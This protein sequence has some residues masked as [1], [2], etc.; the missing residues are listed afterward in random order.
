MFSSGGFLENNSLGIGL[1]IT[2]EGLLDGSL[3][4]DLRFGGD[5][6][7]TALLDAMSHNRAPSAFS[8]PDTSGSMP[9]QGRSLALGSVIPPSPFSAGGR[10]LPPLTGF[11]PQAFS[12]GASLDPL[13]GGFQNPEVSPG[14]SPLTHT[15]QNLEVSSLRGDSQH[16]LTHPSLGAVVSNIPTTPAVLG[17]FGNV[18]GNKNVKLTLNDANGTEVTF[19]LKGKGHGQVVGGPAFQ[20]LLITGTDDQSQV[21]IKTKGKQSET[22]ITD[23]IVNGS[24]KELKATTTDLLG[25]LTSTGAI[26]TLELD[27]VA[28]ATQQTVAMG[29]DGASK[30]VSLKFDQ[31]SDVTVQLQTPVK[32][33]EAT[34]WL[35]QNLTLD[36]L[37]TPSVDQLRIDG[38]K[39]RNLAGDFQAGLYLTGSGSAKPTLKQVDIDGQV[40]DGIWQVVG[41]TNKLTFGSTAASWSANIDGNLKQLNVKSEV[42]GTLAAQEIGIIE[43]KGDL[44]QAQILSGTNLGADGLLGG[45]DAASDTFGAGSIRSVKVKG[46]GIDSIV[47]AGLDPVDGVFNN[48]NDQL[49]DELESAIETLVIKGTASADSLFAA[50]V[51]PGKVKIDGLT[52]NPEIDAR[53]LTPSKV[54]QDITAPVIT[55]ALV[56]DTAAGG[57]TNT[58]GITADATIAGTVTDTSGIVSLRAGLDDMLPA[59]FTEITAILQPDGQFSLDLAQ[60]TSI[61]GGAL[62]DG[63]YTLHLQAVDT[64]GNASE[65]IDV[66]FTLDTTEPILELTTP[67]VTGEHSSTARLIGT[68]EDVTAGIAEVLYDLDG[69]GF[70]GLTPDAGG[71]FDQALSAA[72]LPNGSHQLTLE[73]TDVA[74]NTT[75]T[76]LDFQVSE[77]LISGPS[78]STGWALRTIDGVVLAERDSLVSQAT[79]PV[80]LRQ[81]VGSRTLSF[82]L[83]AIFDTSDGGVP[84]RLLVYLVDANDPSQTLLDQGVSGTPVF[85]LKETG[86][87]FQPGLVRYNGTVVEIDVTSLTQVT[88]GILVFQLLNSDGDTGSVVEVSNLA[89]QMDET[90]VVSPIF[91]LQSNPVAPGPAL[92]LSSLNPSTDLNIVLSQVQFD[93]Q[94]GRYTANV[95]VE[96]TGDPVGRQVALVFANLPA[97]VELLNSSGADSN[98]FPYLNLKPSI[99]T[100]GLATGE[101]SDPIQ[102]V[103]DNPNL[104][105]F[106][107]QPQILA[108][109][110]NRAPVFDAVTLPDLLPGGVFR[111]PLQA[112]DPDGDSVTFSLQSDVALPTGELQGD[113]TLVFQPTPDQLG[114]YTFFLVASDGT[115]ETTQEV[116]LNVVS[117]PITTTRISGV[118]QNTDQDPLVGVVIELG[119]AQT[120]TAADG[121]FLLKVNDFADDT[122]KVR[123][124]GISGPDVYPF[125]A[126]KLPLLF[127]H[128][129]FMGVNNVIE[130]PIYLPALDM[131]N[132]QM[133]DPA[134]DVTVTTPNIG[135]AAVMVTAGSLMDQQGNAFEGVLSITEVPTDLTPAALPKGLNPDL[136]VT[137]QPGE[138]VFE[139][140]AA[141]TLPNTAGY[142]PGVEMD[143]W[144][145]NPET[146]DFDK[147]GLGQ[148]SADGSVIETIEGGIRNSSWHFFLPILELF[149][150]VL[151]LAGNRLNQDN[152]CPCPAKKVPSNSEIE[153]HSG[154]LTETHNLVSYQSLGQTRGL[155]LTYDSL[156]ADP[157]PIVH[158][159]YEDLNPEAITNAPNSLKLVAKVTVNGDNFTYQ[160][161]GYQGTDYGLS[162]GEHIWSIPG[163]RGQVDAA[164]QIDLKDLPSG[165]YDYSLESGIYL[166]FNNQ[167]TGRSTTNNSK[168]LHINS[169]GSIF[170]NGWGISGLQELVENP[171]GSVLL[172]DGDG[173][174]MLFQPPSMPEGTYQS[175][176]ADFST[177]EKLADGTF[178]RTMKDQTV[179]GFNG[180]NQLASV[181]DRNG[182]ET[183]YLYDS[184]HRIRSVI[185]PVGLETTF[186]YTNNRVSTITD[187]A[188]RITQL[189]HDAVGNLTRVSDPDGTSRTWEYDTDYH[190]VAEVD[191]RGNREESFFNFAG[192]ATGAVRKDGSVVQVDPL[193]VQ[194]L[195]RPEETI[196]P[197][198]APT[199]FTLS[200]VTA[201]HADGNGNVAVSLLNQVGQVVSATD[202]SGA[203][204]SVE[205]NAQNLI[206][207]QTDARGNVTRFEYDDQGNVLEIQDTF[208]SDTAPLGLFAEQAYLT[209]SNP[210]ALTLNDFN[211]DAFLDLATANA[212][213][214]SVSVLLG[215]AEGSF[216][217][218][219]DYAV[220]SSPNAVQAADL[221]QDGYL[222]LITA[223]SSVS[224]GSVS[225]LLGNGNGSF[226]N[227]TDIAV[228]RAPSA[229]EVG[230]LNQDGTL[231]IVAANRLDN[232]ISVL[233]GTGNGTFE[234]P[235]TFDTD[236]QPRSLALEDFDNDGNIDIVT[237]NSSGNSLS[238]L[239]GDGNGFFVPRQDYTIGGQPSMVVTADINGDGDLDLISRERFGEH[240]SVSLGQGDG[241]FGNLSTVAVGSTINSLVLGDL[242]GDDI[243]DITVSTQD[244]Q[245]VVLSG[246]GSGNFTVS[247]DYAVSGRPE[248]LALADL[249]GDSNLDVVALNPSIDAATIFFGRND[250]TLTILENTYSTGVSPKSVALGDLNGD[251]Y[252]DVVTGSNSSSSNSVALRF[253]NPDGTFGDRTDLSV[254]KTPAFVL[255]EDL[256]GDSDLD[257][258][259]VNSSNNNISVLLGNGD[260]SFA[261]RIDYAVRRTPSS[262]TI[263]D[264]DGDGTLDLVTVN[265]SN[266]LISIL[267][268]RGDG[269]FIPE[270]YAVGGVPTLVELGDLNGDG[271]SDI[272]TANPS[273]NSLSLLFGQTD[274]TLS[275]PTAYSLS[276]SPK[277]IELSDL[278]RDGDLDVVVIDNRQISVLLG[279]G[280][281]LFSTGPSYSVDD[282]VNG[283]V[284]DLLALGDVNGDDVLDLVTARRRG[285][286][287]VRLGNGDGTFATRLDYNVG[288]SPQSLTLT[289]LDGDGRLDIATLDANDRV[290]LLWGN[291]DGTFT[292]E[293]PIYKV[294][295]L[296][297]S[298]IGDLNGDSFL[299]F[300]GCLSTNRQSVISTFGQWGWH[301]QSST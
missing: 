22:A 38:H 34:E 291:G 206:T 195:Y 190:M 165:Q 117:D 12:Q 112:T 114:S 1:G 120:T 294:E 168:I 153:L 256:D 42:Q 180:Q 212:S 9:T 155:T 68:V 84:D 188:G 123:G 23:I 269:T 43:I 285:G 109:G 97:G 233:L 132:G 199:T 299:D 49:R 70:S 259:T 208:V 19:E 80:T 287:S 113:G 202:G 118:I 74:G 295:G 179:Y 277:S 293:I 115:L 272:V 205:R 183:R 139:T 228:G 262:L 108:S 254:G 64:A 85:V 255:L 213:S 282:I 252:L 173:N 72:G 77:N 276:Y 211:G 33:L 116:T 44:V 65:I 220:G 106:A 31:L 8:N 82:D 63:T 86:A 258:V 257:I 156:R 223:N 246:D 75:Q 286:V 144:S 128:D 290:N 191:K 51:F 161:P 50:G 226:A 137:I 147:V 203:L 27:D 3:L 59:D 267:L 119:T 135:G 245:L 185:D 240:I 25:H 58:D 266:D 178:R 201:A 278:D 71:A 301:L 192:R 62:L 98:G 69:Q 270:D 151:D 186:T 142:A 219:T 163:T 18:G 143:L 88:Q 300:C 177:L 92:D 264:I 215:N 83:N 46:D 225:I 279:D 111:L 32:S 169:I 222:D 227:R 131:V 253:G 218:R 55:A 81:A 232:T 4:N 24:L 110:P 231:D 121:S 11:N 229:V 239:L 52:I 54:S 237:A 28:S 238:V 5:P 209:G 90:G 244:R 210:Q 61:N 194:G 16:S 242:D 48:G 30:K 247:Q 214:A 187:P 47:G 129:P 275:T 14:S 20:Q 99:R 7:L 260:G 189:E 281:G 235:N 297:L 145:I 53:F 95:Q 40:S 2:D 21:E 216:S 298:A 73:V 265:S 166:F 37:A 248:E 268:G 66:N 207:I 150:G 136:V 124:E 29:G 79:L 181:Q 170:G 45:T 89:S 107:L 134:Q 127:G 198:A 283:G 96:N 76:Q 172:I 10:N 193:Q 236:L 130:R 280:S 26:Q 296:G 241:S 182:N 56:N 138:M 234:T 162:G 140:P 102:L 36:L 35:D 159:G 273:S 39:K 217:H 176:A 67:L 261:P 149:E 284:L 250:G 101:T 197:L 13:T 104:L 41:D 154:A 103:I 141:I 126:E 289:D 292:Y 87:E 157:R 15:T 57:T 221:N 204:P 200:E 105:L 171:D 93:V 122:L 133:I 60:L 94:T 230:D 158:L 184:E 167:F 263:T 288:E 146:G 148:V 91:P 100:G 125:I 249:N 174:E 251:G 17:E 274:G 78:D 160:V 164:L 224:Q 175:P 6:S 152:A 271:L 196:N 243:L